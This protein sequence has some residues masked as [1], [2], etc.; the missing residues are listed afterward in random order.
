MRKKKNRPVLVRRCGVGVV[1]VVVLVDE[2]GDWVTWCDFGRLESRSSIEQIFDADTVPHV[3]SHVES[4]TG[5]IVT[6]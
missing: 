6:A 4:K 5:E 3:T 1:V 2:V